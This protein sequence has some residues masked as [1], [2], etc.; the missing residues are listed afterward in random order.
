MLLPSGDQDGKQSPR[1]PRASVT[2]TGLAPS[3]SITQ[4]CITGWV[5]RDEQ[6]AMRDPSGESVGW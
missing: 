3:A 5:S 4:T 6:N 2:R 1:P